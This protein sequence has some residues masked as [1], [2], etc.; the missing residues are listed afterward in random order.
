MYR[1]TKVKKRQRSVS[2]LARFEE[3]VMKLLRIVLWSAIPAALLLAACGKPPAKPDEV[4]PVRTLTVNAGA[5]LTGNTYA[6]E[7]RPRYESDLG[8]RVS[9]KIL[10]RVVNVGDQVRKG[11]LLAQ[12]DPADMALN[13]ASQR[14]QL[15]SLDAQLNVARLDYERNRKLFEEGVIGAAGLDHYRATFDAAQAQVEA[16][17]AQVRAMSNQT[18]YTELRADHDGIITAAMGEPGQVV[19]AGQTVMRL[20]HSGE[21]EI[22]TSVP[23]DQVGRMRVGLP[24]QV[25]LWSAP[26][27]P[28]QGSIRELASSA[29]SATRTYAVRVAVL[30]P[31]PQMKLGMTATVSVPLEGP[32]LVR[33]PMMALVEQREQKGVW[34][35]DAAAQAVAFRPIVVAGVVGNDIL[36]GGGL[37]DGDVVITAGAPLLQQGQKVRPMTDT[38]AAG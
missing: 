7:V 8:F 22:A 23:E 16:G 10:K 1:V 2:T 20:A 32:K 24:V 26:G 9:G 38:A 25:A 27:V 13:E 30:Q 4:R 18:G 19:T 11:A 28:A 6:G 36:V 12:L 14:A 3:P 37:N 34:L 33:I 5:T 31:P 21:I 17:R 15:N 35:Y 29:D